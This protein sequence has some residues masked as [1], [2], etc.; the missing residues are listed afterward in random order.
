MNP[1]VEN[2][3]NAL[4]SIRNGKNPISNMAPLE[5][6]GFYRGLRDDN[7]IEFYPD[8]AINSTSKVRLTSVG[9]EHLKTLKGQ[10]NRKLLW[11]LFTAIV[12]G[13]IA[14]AVKLNS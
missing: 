7:L 5:S 9:E 10:G 2:K 13:L 14:L 11:F 4:E 6:I 8:G 3:I 1:T 12:S